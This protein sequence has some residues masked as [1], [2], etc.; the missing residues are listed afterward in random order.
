MKISTVETEF[1][2]DGQTNIQSD[3]TKLIAALREFANAPKSENTY[4]VHFFMH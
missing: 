2:A 4:Q 3:M 1:Y